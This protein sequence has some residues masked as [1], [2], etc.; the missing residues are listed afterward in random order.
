MP[1]TLPEKGG[2]RGEGNC[3]TN[4]RKIRRKVGENSGKYVGN[5]WKNR[6]N[7]E[8][9]CGNGRE[10]SAK[11][12]K[13]LK[14]PAKFRKNRKNPANFSKIRGNFEEGPPLTLPPSTTP[15]ASEGR[16]IRG[17]SYNVRRSEPSEDIVPL[18]N[19]LDLVGRIQNHVAVYFL[20]VT[21]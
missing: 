10:I 17:S 7:S 5:L 2:K 19:K 12:R 9:F 20:F 1:P 14:N 4:G 21:L 6:G 11:F 16:R 15:H 18:S 8:A 3:F 13:N